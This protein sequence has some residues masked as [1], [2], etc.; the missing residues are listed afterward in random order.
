MQKRAIIDTNVVLRYLF[1]DDA[2]QSPE[3]IALIDKAPSGSLYL[4]VIVLA[5]VT[6]TL[7]SHFGVPRQDIC[8][9]IQRF[10]AQPSISIDSIT[11]GAV[12]RFSST[13][14]DFA[15]CALAAAGSHALLPIITYDRDFKKFN[16]VESTRPSEFLT[17]K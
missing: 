7:R 15:D 13:N 6:W 16:D 2:I 10:I 11:L 8:S 3:A 1:G 9:A 17:R 14:L 4:S 12:A 5:E